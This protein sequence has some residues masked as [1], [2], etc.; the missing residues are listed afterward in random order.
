MREDLLKSPY[1]IF[2]GELSQDE[3]DVGALMADIGSSITLFKIEKGLT[4][5]E[6]AKLMGADLKVLEAI[7][8]GEYEDLVKKGN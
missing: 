1:S 5:V 8:C 2:E 4:Q 3:M 6:M 7:E